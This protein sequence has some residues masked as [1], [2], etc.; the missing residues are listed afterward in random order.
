MVSQPLTKVTPVTSQLKF[1]AAYAARVPHPHLISSNRSDG[2]KFSLLH[3]T[4]NL[5]SLCCPAAYLDKTSEFG[6]KGMTTVGPRSYDLNPVHVLF[7]SVKT[8][9]RLFGHGGLLRLS[10]GMF[11]S[12]DFVF[13]KQQY[14][15]GMAQSCRIIH[16]LNYV[17]NRIV[18]ASQLQNNTCL[19][20]PQLLLF[21]P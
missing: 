18:D 16:H 17:S 21:I 13:G 4:D 9:M 19:T 11:T 15:Q 20:H 7:L 12:T 5:L 10:C 3:T 2:C 14:G 6:N 8:G 1:F